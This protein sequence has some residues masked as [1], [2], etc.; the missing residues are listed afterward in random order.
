MA[1]VVVTGMRDELCLVGWWLCLCGA[2]ELGRR[3][4][5]ILLS[6]NDWMGVREAGT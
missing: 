1:A 5:K 3:L 2:A 6:C 4:W